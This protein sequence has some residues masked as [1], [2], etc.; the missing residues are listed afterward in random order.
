MMVKRAYCRKTED[1]QVRVSNEINDG[2]DV[3]PQVLF[4]FLS[5]FTAGCLSAA[6]NAKIALKLR[7][8]LYLSPIIE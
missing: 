4:L 5:L 1:V 8:L 7:L 3:I 6:R 2:E